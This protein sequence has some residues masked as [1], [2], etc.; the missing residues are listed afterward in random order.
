M[1]DD[2]RLLNAFEEDKKMLKFMM[3][4]SWTKVEINRVDLFKEI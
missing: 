1:L 4:P 2:S 3:K